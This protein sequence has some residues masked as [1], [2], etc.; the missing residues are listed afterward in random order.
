MQ[1]GPHICGTHRLNRL[2]VEFQE[3]GKTNIKAVDKKL[4]AINNVSVT[5][6]GLVV[7]PDGGFHVFLNTI[8]VQNGSLRDVFQTYK[9]YTSICHAGLL[10]WHSVLDKHFKGQIILDDILIVN[11]MDYAIKKRAQI[12]GS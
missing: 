7:D 5:T 3:P 2:A 10:V 9:G 11:D 8:A 6:Y 1:I 12:L 4:V